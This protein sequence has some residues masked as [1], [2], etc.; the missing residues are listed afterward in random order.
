MDRPMLNPELHSEEQDRRPLAELLRLALP[1]VAQMASYTL[2]QFL[3]T[4]MLSRVGDRIA[5]PTAAANSGILA[6]SVISLGMGVMWVV[7]TLVSQAYGRKDFAA[8]GQFLWQGVW[9]ALV[10]SLL[11]LPLLPLA[12]RAFAFLGHEPRLAQYEAVYLQI[13]VGL[14]SLKLVGT[15]FQQFLLAVD[16]ASAVMVAT[17]VGVATN[18]LAAWVLIFGHMGA[19]PMGVVGAAWAQNIGVGVET[20]LAVAFALSPAIRRT[21][22]VL[23]WRLRMTQMR[24]LLKVGIPS[25]L[26]VVADVLA[27]GAWGNVV[28]ALFGTKAM[29]GTNFVFRYMSVSFMPAFGISTAV[30]ALVGRYIGRRRPDVAMQRAHLGFKVAAVYMLACATIFI[31]FRRPLMSLFTE[32]PEVLAIGSMMLVFAGVYQLFDA[33][34]IVYYGGLRGAGDTFVPAVATATLCWSITVLGGYLMARYAPQIGPAGPWYLATAYGAILGFWM[35]ARFA[36]GGWR[37]INLDRPRESDTVRNLEMAM[38]S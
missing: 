5:P 4:W 20:L 31:L 12:P 21:F 19:R 27:W 30:T 11:P 32:D 24:T 33:M 15:A 6:F 34:Y 17:M 13:V 22:N 23:D 16:R 8:C 36:R 7:N 2:M 37:S 3:D 29:A 25:G 38:E 26:Q 9:F 1:T 14:A 28:M 18:V 35:Y 10:F